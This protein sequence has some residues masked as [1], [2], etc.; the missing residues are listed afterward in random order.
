MGIAADNAESV[1]AIRAAILLID[2]M[3]G[4]DLVQALQ[5]SQHP[6]RDHRSKS[7]CWQRVRCVWID[8]LEQISHEIRRGR[9]LA[10]T[11]A[12]QIV[13]GPFRYRLKWVDALL[14]CR[15]RQN[16]IVHRQA[17]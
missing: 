5:V 11:I 13:I 9:E 3:A 4:L 10:G 6:K 14:D 15:Q 2:G 16:H 8:H 7:L 17:A 1:S 12:A